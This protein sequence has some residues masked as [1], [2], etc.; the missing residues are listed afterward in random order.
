[1][2]QAQLTQENTSL[3]ALR[4][5]ELV[6]LHL[7]QYPTDNE[8]AHLI[9]TAFEFAQRAHDGQKRE[10]GEPYFTHAYNT[11]HA[12]VGWKLDAQT[13][14][15]GLL[16]D[17]IE[18]CNVSP[19]TI[20]KE[21]GD[22]VKFLVESI[23]K[24]SKLKYRGNERSLESLRKMI[25]A[26]SKDLRVIFIKLA[27][28]L[29]NMRTLEHVPVSKQRRIA[30][31]TTEV[32][33][34]LASRLG[35]QHLSGELEDLAFP[36]LHPQQYEWMQKNLKESFEE[37][38]QYLVSIQPLVAQQMEIAHVHP[39]AIDYRAKRVSSLY[40]KLVRY[41][42][43]LE[44]IYDL[45]AMRI[46]V[47]TIDECYLA[48]GALH[49]LWRPLPGRIKDY[50]A[51]P[52]PNG[53]QSL[54]TTVLCVDEKPIEFQI[55]TLEMH[56]QAENG[57]AAH[58]FYEAQKGTK[59]YVRSQA[60]SANKQDISIV[61]QLK[62]WQNQ[63]PGSQE[64]IDA[65]KVDIFSDRIFVLTPKGE[66]I[67]LPAGA[68]PVD[69][70]YTIHS[71]IGNSCVGAKVNNKIVPLNYQLQSGDLVEIL[72][73][74]NKKP[75]ES[76]LEFA[77]THYALKKIKNTI[78]HKN[79]M[80]KKTEYRIICENRIGIAKDLLSIFSRNKIPLESVNTIENGRFPTIK[81]IADISSREKAEQLF[82]KL[83]KVDG[84]KETHLR[85]I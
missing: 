75:S 68:T 63:F 3:N 2:S 50:I 24:L 30:L 60:Q 84:V 43:N 45:I 17:T 64:F 55:R 83:R 14:A 80:P 59:N 76:W 10:S 18:D 62:E 33:A 28:R 6:T 85:L 79:Q 58:W 42:M 48:L 1:M 25:L 74:K 73:Q 23:T 46:M 82:L 65:L 11:A 32:Y 20:R 57:A 54:H 53:Y 27:D 41:D 22:D 7:N 29:H 31:E 21:F 37:R 81:I 8:G 69:F 13:I 70:A 51:L 15:A 44:H 38:M 52:K 39:I 4:A 78:N 16:H 67:D 19:E 5:E 49:Q 40:K 66:P 77:K 34:P 9:R 12:L 35:M 72:T 26:T 71:E 56:E 61:R 47:P 36:Y